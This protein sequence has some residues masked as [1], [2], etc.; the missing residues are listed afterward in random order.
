MKWILI[1]MLKYRVNRAEK[2]KSRNGSIIEQAY[3]NM[4]RN[5]K[6]TIMFLE[7]EN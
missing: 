1:K 2:R 5:Y 6:N 3:N 7:A 4:I